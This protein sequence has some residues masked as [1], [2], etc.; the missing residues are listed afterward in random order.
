VI[1][2]LRG[3]VVEVS[4]SKVGRCQIDGQ[5]VTFEEAFDRDFEVESERGGVERWKYGKDL[6]FVCRENM[7]VPFVGEKQLNVSPTVAARR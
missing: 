1:A 5:E 4:R 6:M 7:A 2:L 3:G